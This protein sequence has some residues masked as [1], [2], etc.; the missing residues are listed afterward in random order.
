M[1]QWN[2]VQLEVRDGRVRQ[3]LNG[4]LVVEYDLW[5][6]EWEALVAASK[7]GTMPGYG[8]AKRGHLALQ[9]HGDEVSYRSIRVLTY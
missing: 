8:R 5:T 3:W 4:F 1:G 6:P 2:E 7:F 9:D